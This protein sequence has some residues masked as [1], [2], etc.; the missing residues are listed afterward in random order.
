MSL[1]QH[2]QFLK[3]LER[4]KR[5]LI[6]LAEKANEDDFV[7]AFGIAALLAKLSKPVEI[8]TAGGNVP[9]SL[10]FLKKTTNVR[11]DLPNIRKMTI[12]INAREAKVD[13]LSYAVEN[14]ELKI[15]LV[16]KTGA[17]TKDDVKISTDDYRFDLIITI[18][19]KDLE[20][21]GELHRKYADFFFATPII[22]IDHTTDN[23]HYGQ[24]NLV[25][26]NAVSSSE[27]CHDLFKEIDAS[28]IDEEIATYFLTGMIYKT[29]SFR[30]ENV[31]PQT[32]KIA[33]E[34]I[35]RG[36]RRDEIVNNLYKTRT[37]E[38]LRLW[39]RALA[40]LKSDSENGFVWTLLNRQDF[41]NAGA[42]EEALEAV[43]EELMMTSP[44]A[45]VAAI[46]YEDKDY[47]VRAF[48]H[49]QRPHDAIALGAP[50]SAS[51][52]RERAYL[53]LKEKDLLKAE[54]KVIAHIKK[55]LKESR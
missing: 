46:F 27:V 32:L 48:L 55:T 21:L 33:G 10:K 2:E 54:K 4:S 40:R 6:V 15:H 44:E 18:G 7:S 49:A 41:T 34:L 36:A 11:G 50:F 20:A 51:G 38:T 42:D 13:E 8:A 29:K 24:M 39:G 52:T 26:I 43:I 17:W 30:S 3:L 16:P 53:N 37:V 28:L 35:A 1:K 45:G 19:A 47:N 25:N 12:T 9:Q 31:S 5:P 14:G 23:E 22:N